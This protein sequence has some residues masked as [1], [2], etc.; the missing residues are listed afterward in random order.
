M[1]QSYFALSLLLLAMAGPMLAVGRVSTQSSLTLRVG[2][3]TKAEAAINVTANLRSA[4]PS[5][6]TFPSRRFPTQSK[7]PVERKAAETANRPAI[8]KTAGLEKPA[9]ACCQEITPVTVTATSPPR[10]NTSDG[11]LRRS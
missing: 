2:R 6:L 4:A 3:N 9:S 5:L 1:N 11:A 8:V 7:T 10:N